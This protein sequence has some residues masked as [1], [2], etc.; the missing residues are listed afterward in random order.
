MNE[1]LEAII[2]GD[3][4]K[5][6]WKESLEKDKKGN[7]KNSLMNFIIILGNDENLQSIS[8][9]H[10]KKCI[11]VNGQL[12]WEKIGDKWNKFDMASLNVYIEKNYGIYS[13]GKIKDALKII[14]IYGYDKS[15]QSYLD[16]LPK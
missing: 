3:S 9:N 4:T 11:Q 6:Q 1:F 14:A 2:K 13:P 8:F 12:P 7:I 5:N 10:N 16:D 15:P